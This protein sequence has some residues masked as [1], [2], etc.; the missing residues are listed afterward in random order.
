MTLSEDQL[1]GILQTCVNFARDIIVKMGG[2]GPFGGRV[3]LDGELEF[4]AFQISDDAPT[5]QDLY[6]KAEGV[7][8]EEA[9]QGR[10]LAA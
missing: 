10:L 8:I 2:F 4:F 1:A 3:R 6:M 7:L 5:L 9:R